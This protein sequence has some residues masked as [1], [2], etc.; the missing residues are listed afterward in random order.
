MGTNK[1]RYKSYQRG[2]SMLET[3]LAVFIVVIITISLT[4]YV[5]SNA[6]TLNLRTDAELL[7]NLENSLRQYIIANPSKVLVDPDNPAPVQINVDDIK[8]QGFLGNYVSSKFYDSLA[9]YA[10]PLFS[11]HKGQHNTDKYKYF[12]G[13]DFLVVYTPSKNGTMGNEFN[14]IG[15]GQLIHF[16]GPKGGVYNKT[17]NIVSGLTGAWKI[18][19]AD[20]S[21]DEDIKRPEEKERNI[22]IHAVIPLTQKESEIISLSCYDPRTKD[23]CSTNKIKFSCNNSNGDLMQKLIFTYSGH[24]VDTLTMDDKFNNITNYKP[25]SGRGV[26]E[27]PLNI[28]CNSSIGKDF[29]F[30]P[31][32]TPSNNNIT[33]KAFTF[34]YVLNMEKN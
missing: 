34:L 22:Y 32:V 31:I 13:V 29:K 18:I 4:D 27:F 12:Y 15:R 17:D 33:G 9:I 6:K 20:Y 23:V 14:S 28:F 21:N 25:A 30:Q 24:D 19:I 26:F 10:K 2:F 7:V 3:C 16:I 1:L 11:D 8:N 5:E